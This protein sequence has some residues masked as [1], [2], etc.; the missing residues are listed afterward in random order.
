MYLG[1]L[2][3][4]YIMDFGAKKMVKEYGWWRVPITI[5]FTLNILWLKTINRLK[6]KIE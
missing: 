5:L 4:M 3:S 2:S 6:K 1:F